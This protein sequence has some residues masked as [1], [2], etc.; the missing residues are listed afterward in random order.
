MMKTSLEIAEWINEKVKDMLIDK[1]LEEMFNEPDYNDLIYEIELIIEQ[2]IN[3]VKTQTRVEY[4]RQ[5]R[6]FLNELDDINRMEIKLEPSLK[7]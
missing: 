1:S 2:T 4:K 7:D 6:M 3:L 5:I